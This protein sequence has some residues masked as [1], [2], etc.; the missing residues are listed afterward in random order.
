M[1]IAVFNA[2]STTLKF[3]L[4][5]DDPSRGPR[6]RGRISGYGTQAR[7]ETAGV[8]QVPR[9]E[10]RAVH[11]AS[12]AARIA[13]AALKPHVTGGERVVVGHRLVL[14][15]DQ[16]APIRLD[17]TQLARLTQ[18]VCLDPLHLR[19]ALDVIAAARSEW[20]PAAKAAFGISDCTFFRDLPEAARAVA[21]PRELVAE[22]G[23]RRHG[24]HGLAHRSMLG[25][26]RALT[27][28]SR[29]ARIVSFQ[30]GGGCSAAAIADGMP[31][32]TSMG[33]SP[34]D[35]LLMAT[36]CGDL[37][38]GI[39]L[40]L[41][42]RGH[43]VEELDAILHRRSGLAALSGADPDMHH[44]LRLEE[45]G[46]RPSHLAVEAF[47]HR[48]RKY[49]GAYLAVLAG[50][51]AVLFGGGIGENA[52]TIRARI[53]RDMA[54]AGLELGP[55]NERPIESIAPI[56]TPTSAVSAFVVP[57]DEEAVIASDLR[58]LVDTEFAHVS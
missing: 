56:G 51:D 46:H 7:Y 49:L 32:E 24:F 47:C 6:I 21:L 39:L 4:Y 33:F 45:Q 42:R 37:D 34:L 44:L 22:H 29:H 57:V 50:A 41:M 13:V 26:Y 20:R 16:D 12:H 15:T 31:V 52:P 25:Q 10:V 5:G 30:L 2:G 48:A 54:W 14:A 53:C 36:R 58:H 18:Q 28:A 17:Q 35:G 11:D 38:P 43:P 55:G 40:H 19:P 8:G 23:L 3:A 1:A 27:G 9:H